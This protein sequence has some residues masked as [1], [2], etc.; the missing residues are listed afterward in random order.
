MPSTNSFLLAHQNCLRA[1]EQGQ[2][3]QDDALARFQSLQDLHL[4]DAGGAG[5]DLPQG[6]EAVGEDLL[7]LAAR[8]RYGG[9]SDLVAACLDKAGR[10]KEVEVFSQKL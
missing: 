3:G 9:R 2:V 6:G 5:A 4:A 10:R 7:S 8:S 1:V